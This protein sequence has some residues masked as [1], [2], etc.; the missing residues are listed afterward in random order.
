[1]MPAAG[2]D[3]TP[4]TFHATHDSAAAAMRPI[5]PSMMPDDYH[6]S[7]AA[8]AFDAMSATYDMCC[9]FFLPDYSL[10]RCFI[11]TPAA[12]LSRRCHF[13]MSVIFQMVMITSA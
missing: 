10:F 8:A 1:M 5:S 7:D 4:F 3:A 6:A 2:F 13:T 9:H 12:D 11:D